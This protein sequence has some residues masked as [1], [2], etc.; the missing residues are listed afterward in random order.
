MTAAPPGTGRADEG[1]TR[2]QRVGNRD[3][4][5]GR[6]A[7]VGAAQGVAV[8][9]SGNHR[10]RRVGLGQ[11]A[12]EI[13]P[14][15]VLEQLEG[16]VDIVDR[17]VEVG[18]DRRLHQAIGEMAGV[19][20]RDRRARSHRV[21]SRQ[22]CAV[23]RIGARALRQI[24][25]QRGIDPGPGELGFDSVAVRQGDAS[26]RDGDRRIRTAE[27]GGRAARDVVGSDD[28][29]GASRLCIGDFDGETAG[30][31]IDQRDIAVDRRTVGERRA[32]IVDGRT[33]GIGGID[34]EDDVAGHASGAD[35]R[36]EGG[37]TDLIEAGDSGRTIH[38][39]KGRAQ[40][41][42]AGGDRVGYVRAGPCDL[43]A[44]NRGSLDR[45][46]VATGRIDLR[47][48]LAERVV[49]SELRIGVGLE[50]RPGVRPGR[51]VDEVGESQP[52]AELV[53]EH[54]DEIG[55]GAVVGVEAVV[56]AYA[57][58][59]CRVTVQ[60]AVEARDDVVG[61]RVR[62]SRS[63]V[64]RRELV[65]QGNGVPG[66]GEACVR[67]VGEDLNRTCRTENRG[68]R[69][70]GERVERRLDE[71]VDVAVD[72]VA[73]PVGG[74]L[75]RV[76]PL[77]P[78]GGASVATH[79]SRGRRIIEPLASAVVVDDGKGGCGGRTR[80]QQREAQSEG[81]EVPL[82]AHDHS[83]SRPLSIGICFL[84]V[85]TATAS[86]GV[87]AHVSFCAPEGVRVR[88]ETLVNRPCRSRPTVPSE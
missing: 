14:P 69:R 7:A 83:V 44:A 21:E 17:W 13:E 86:S 78:N 10:I 72:Q 27:A 59:A 46:L 29:G 54:G 43:A 35:R 22:Q 47:P 48:G 61:V 39:Q 70:A 38:S 62:R 4:P 63:Q 84:P 3:G 1:R 2:G 82:C 81:Y 20:V 64:G 50:W 58:E 51:L 71:D 9:G 36:P 53:E 32:G 15:N 30:T 75:E 19:V 68:G 73:P 52:V 87:S 79:R 26:R 5:V 18:V 55:V 60:V 40:L 77:L 23:G 67:K 45:G 11:R 24:H 80:G 76:Q 28:R 42:S 49:A 66:I 85:S 88:M 12:V 31:A 25:Q 41:Q 57:A 37:R 74:E 65:G 8:V 6:G 33:G 56:P 34:R 16:Q